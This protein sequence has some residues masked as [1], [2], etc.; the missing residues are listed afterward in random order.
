MRIHVKCSHLRWTFL[1]FTRMIL[2]VLTV[3]EGWLPLLSDICF[4]GSFLLS[5]GQH[6]LPL[7]WF[8]LWFVLV[9]QA[10]CC[11]T[12]HDMSEL[13]NCR[14]HFKSLKHS[15]LPLQ[16][17]MAEPLKSLLD[18]M[19]CFMPKL[20]G[21]FSNKRF[22][23]V[24]SSFIMT[25]MLARKLPSS[26]WPSFLSACRRLEEREL[27]LLALPRWLSM[28]TQ[29]SATCFN[30]SIFFWLVL[31]I[32]SRASNTLHMHC[33]VELYPQPDDMSFISLLYKWQNPGHLTF[34]SFL[35]SEC[36][37]WLFLVRITVSLLLVLLE[38]WQLNF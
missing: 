20:L 35:R 15:P 24:V 31:G 4:A 25:A 26:P 30:Y 22:T 36:Y 1:F 7:L 23:S 16:L 13:V 8:C 29:L 11:L 17:D 33:T 27:C 12:V 10:S 28:D 38:Q 5:A 21:L 2:T 6:S 3:L 34:K 18:W 19:S 9:G 32:K 14:K 37:W